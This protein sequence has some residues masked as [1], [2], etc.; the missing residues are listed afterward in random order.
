GVVEVD[1]VKW[2]FAEHRT[3]GF[4]S[5]PR[6][7]GLLRQ[8]RPERSVSAAQCMHGHVLVIGERSGWGALLQYVVRIGAMHDVHL[9]P[10]PRESIHQPVQVHGVPAEAVRGVE[11]R[12]MAKLK[13]SRHGCS[14][15]PEMHPEAAAPSAATKDGSRPRVLPFACCRA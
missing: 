6:R 14:R 2:L 12:K 4:G 5:Q 13:R 11:D 10:A 7:A 1:N 8:Q 15:P 9:V 3:Y